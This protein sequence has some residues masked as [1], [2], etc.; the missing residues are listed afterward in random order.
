MNRR[1]ADVIAG[2]AG[3][4]IAVIFWLQ[5]TNLQP[6]SNLFPKV[7]EIC[8][9]VGGLIAV[10][11][12]LLINNQTTQDTGEKLNWVKAI[13]IIIASM[14]YVVGMVYIGFYVTTVLYLTLG[15][16]YLNDIKRFSLKPVC[17][18]LMFGMGVT[19]V[20]YATFSLFLK[21]PTPES[22]LF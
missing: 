21:V 4:L 22:L 13:A 15:S 16:W 6:A 18:S 10:G 5:G 17:F 2:I 7:L 19:I 14:L 11:R 12:G 8:L 9:I 3:I 1:K 20:L